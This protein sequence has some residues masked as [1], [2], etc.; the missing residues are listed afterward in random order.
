V[1]EEGRTED[2]QSSSTA[3][4]DENPFRLPKEISRRLKE[5]SGQH[6]L[7]EPELVKYLWIVV[8]EDRA[9]AQTEEGGDGTRLCANDWL[10]VVDEAAALGVQCMV[11]CL[12]NSFGHWPEVWSVCAWAQEVHHMTVGFQVHDGKLSEEERERLTELDPDRTWLFVPEGRLEGVAALG[13]Q[14]IRVCSAQ[15]GHEDPDRPCD[16]PDS[17]VFV[18]PSGVLYSCGLVLGIDEFRLG[19]V[20]EHALTHVYEEGTSRAVPRGSPRNDHGC[21]GCPNQMAR[22]ILGEQA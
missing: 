2:G 6:S 1:N 12:G 8:S 4:A 9:G 14:G 13:E 16:G 19:H 22:R 11:V 7:D 3:I 10:N 15:V 21:D 20:G 18:G 5:C 17:M